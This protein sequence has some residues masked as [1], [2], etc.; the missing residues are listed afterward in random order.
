MGQRAGART[1]ILPNMVEAVAGLAMLAVPV[2]EQ[3]VALCTGEAVVEEPVEI[4]LRPKLVVH[5][6]HIRLVAV[7]QV[8]PQKL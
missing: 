1:V 6:V 5:G 2:I 8:V 7:A 3:A 4:T